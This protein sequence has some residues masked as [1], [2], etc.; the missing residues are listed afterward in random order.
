MPGVKCGKSEDGRTQEQPRVSGLE[1]S[2]S[3]ALRI[4]APRSFTRR[5]LEHSGPTAHAPEKEGG[6]DAEEKVCL[7]LGHCIH[8]S[9]WG[10]SIAT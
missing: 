8:G 9:A 4:L 7:R 10:T 3:L 2:R 5:C 1:K 6:C